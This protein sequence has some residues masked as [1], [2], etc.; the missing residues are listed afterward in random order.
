MAQLCLI[1]CDPMDYRLARLLCSWDFLGK[2]IGVDCHA[3]LQEIFLTQGSKL[4]LLCLLHWQADSSS[5]S[6][7]GSPLKFTSE[8]LTIIKEI[9]THTLSHIL[10]S[11]TTM[12]CVM[13]TGTHMHTAQGLEAAAKCLLKTH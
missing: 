12:V 6:H 13:D 7:L 1:L 10:L 3:L 9:N 11:V 4:R 8:Q 5:L 2:N